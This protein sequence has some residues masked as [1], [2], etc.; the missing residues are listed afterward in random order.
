V[1]VSVSNEITQS[2]GGAFFSR[3]I[4]DKVDK[5]PDFLQRLWIDEVSLN[6]FTRLHADKNEVASRAARSISASNVLNLPS[7]V[8]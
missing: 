5:G 6:L 4:D 2:S 3:V 7:C 1:F 8:P